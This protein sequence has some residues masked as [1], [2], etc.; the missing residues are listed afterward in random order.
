MIDQQSIPGLHSWLALELHHTTDSSECERLQYRTKHLTSQRPDSDMRSNLSL[1]SKS[2]FILCQKSDLPK[3]YWIG[4]NRKSGAKR[5]ACHVRDHVMRKGSR[6]ES[7]IVC[8]TSFVTDYWS[9]QSFFSRT[10]LLFGLLSYKITRLDFP[11]F[12][13]TI[14]YTSPLGNFRGT[15]F[16]EW[17]SVLAFA[18]FTQMIHDSRLTG[19]IAQTRV[20]ILW[21]W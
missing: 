11:R 16:C 13:R 15:H 19:S 4:D 1:V 8:Y 14:F 21:Q 18:V 6:V 7:M 10:F 2:T 5:I 12:L 17:T 3:D 9:G 20:S